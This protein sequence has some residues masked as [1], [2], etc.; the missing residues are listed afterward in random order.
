MMIQIIMKLANNRQI[1]YFFYKKKRKDSKWIKWIF[2]ESEKEEYIKILK[3][4]VV[5]CL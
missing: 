4:S 1:N 5:L 3:N 2:F